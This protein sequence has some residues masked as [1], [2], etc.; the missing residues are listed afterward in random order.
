NTGTQTNT[1]SVN[2]TSTVSPNTGTQTNTASNNTAS[3]VPSSTAVIGT[4]VSSS[5]ILTTL[6]NDSLTNT[7][8]DY[9]KTLKD[10]MEQQVQK[11]KRGGGGVKFSHLY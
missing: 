3:T 9:Y 1:A 2:T 4:A 11:G 5:T 6:F 8:S 7:S 10:N